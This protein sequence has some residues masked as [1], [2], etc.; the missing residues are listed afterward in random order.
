MSCI[1]REWSLN[2]SIN[3]HINIIILL[4]VE[5]GKEGHYISSLLSEE[6]RK[7]NMEIQST[8]ALFVRGF[9]QER[10]KKMSSS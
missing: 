10:N 7:K 4:K 3:P 6:M 5:L 2:S 8:Y 9:S 1:Y